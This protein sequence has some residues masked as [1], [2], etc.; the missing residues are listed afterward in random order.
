MLW[1]VHE[2]FPCGRAAKLGLSRGLVECRPIASRAGSRLPRQ[3][4]CML[5]LLQTA[6]RGAG[7]ADWSAGNVPGRI[8]VPGMP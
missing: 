8:S 3:R 7:L 2:R 5:M 6:G 4:A 1:I